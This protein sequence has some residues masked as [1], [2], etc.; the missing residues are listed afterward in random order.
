[1][2]MSFYPK[3]LS[4]ANHFIKPSEETRLK[5]LLLTLAE[6]ELCVCELVHAMEL[7]QPKISRYLAQLRKQA[8]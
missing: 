2:V 4:S 7:P 5:I 3:Y 6:T 1:M 8:C